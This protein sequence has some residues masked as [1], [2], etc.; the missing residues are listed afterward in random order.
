MEII[1]AGAGVEEAISRH[2][3]DID[4]TMI[5]LLQRRM[6]AAR[7]LERSTEVT[8]GMAAL[9][10]RL[11][12]EMDRRTASTSMRLLDSLLAIL[13]EGEE[14]GGLPGGGR[15][16]EVQQAARA[17]LRS[18][19]GGAPLE[20]DVLAVAAQLAMRGQSVADELLEDVVD[21]KTFVGEVTALLDGAMEQQQQ[22]VAALEGLAGDAPERPRVEE[23]MNERAMALNLVQ[24]VLTLTRA[25]QK[26]M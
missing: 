15:S 6:D 9:Q 3:A 19:F 17:K 23:V 14:G 10:R 11:K 13:D 18:A 16:T 2:S 21:A 4:D 8:D 5:E 22:L 7:Q 26:D 25:V 1:Q 12:A 24:E 20:A